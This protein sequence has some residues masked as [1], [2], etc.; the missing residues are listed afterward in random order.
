M[1]RFSV[2][3]D[4]TPAQK[5]RWPANAHRLPFVLCSDRVAIRVV[6]LHVDL[7]AEVNP[8]GPQ[9]PHDIIQERPIV[10]D[11][12]AEEATMDNIERILIVAQA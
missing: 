8:A 7:H 12:E 11:A 10:L 2:T 6:D 3:L 1:R 4:S 9:H 5:V